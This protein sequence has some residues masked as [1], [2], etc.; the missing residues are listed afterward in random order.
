MR[1][2]KT[3]PLLFFIAINLL[4]IV[5]MNFCAH[6]SWLPPQDF[7]KWSY[8]GLMF[9]VFLAINVLFVLFWLIFKWKLILLPLAG[10]ALC[11]NSVR[12]YFPINFPSEPPAGSI[13]VLSYNVMAFGNDE[14]TSWNENPIMRYLLGSEAD[15]IC[16]Q[17]AKKRLV[18]DAMDSISSIYPYSHYQLEN[19]NYVAF[20]SKFPIVSVKKIEYPSATNHSYA[21]EILVKED[22]LLVINNHLE[23]YKLTTEDTDDYK[24]ILQNYKHPEQNDSETKYLS[25]TEKIANHDSIRGLQA[26]SVAAYVER[27]QGR[28]I[29]LCGDLNATPISYIHYRLTNYLDDA[30]TRCGNGPGISYNKNR[31]YFRIDHILVS[32]N[33]KAYG[34]K[35]DNSIKHSD[36]YPISCFVKLE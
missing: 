35:V 2:L 24:S 11:A 3:I 16:L 32:P 8:W 14:S 6:T 34:T 4:M 9:P 19:D 20:L 7:S 33:I 13:K 12:A 29:V 28:Y 23:S 25:L 27:N 17:E 18:D 31:M 36:H 30:Y 26:D 10:M 22:T 1:L 21:Y 15:I 5:A